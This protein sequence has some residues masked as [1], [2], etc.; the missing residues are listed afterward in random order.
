MVKTVLKFA[1]LALSVSFIAC[2]NDEYSRYDA[3]TAETPY[4]PIEGRRMV[5]SVKTT[6]TIDGREYSW[7]HKFSYDKH[8]RIRE[9]N[10]KIEHHNYKEA[11]GYTRY[12]KCDITSKANYYYLGE[13]MDVV[14]SVERL[15]PEYPDW[16]TSVSGKDEGRFNANGVLVKYSVLD[17]E[18]SLT[19]L[20]TAYIDGGRRYDVVRG[21]N[22][23]ITGYRLYDELADTLMLDHSS[24][25]DYSFD[26]NKTN[27][28]FSGYFGYWGVEQEIPINSSV[29]YAP[30][31]L[32]A[33]GMLGAGAQNLPLGM[34]LTDSSGNE[35]TGEW[36]LDKDGYPQSFVD[37]YGR[38]TVIT[39]V[40]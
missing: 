30:Y 23:N 10:S 1:I 26:K 4:K 39:Y 31:Q 33:F 8:G 32:A 16:N 14:Y 28:D 40:E 17:L 22:S 2:D 15:Y 6:N 5:A 18:Y 29:Y 13:A 38:K 25:Y 34:V 7:E 12:Y 24:R 11:F 37:V 9:I 20:N 35:I 36:V 3:D 27:F 19:S 21:K